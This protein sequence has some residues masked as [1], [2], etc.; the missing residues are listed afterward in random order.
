MSAHEHTDRGFALAREEDWAGAIEA[1]R[2]AIQ[3]DFR[4]ARAFGNLA[5]AL[6]KVGKHEEAIKICTEGLKYAN[7]ST[8]STD[9]TIIVA[10]PSPA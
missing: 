3:V 5:F 6:N 10:S 2:Q 9:C 4:Y 1:Y 7:S 8:T